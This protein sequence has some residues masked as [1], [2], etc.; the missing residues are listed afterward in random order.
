MI[1]FDR[2]THYL[3]K[4]RVALPGENHRTDTRVPTSNLSPKVIEGGLCFKDYLRGA[5][6]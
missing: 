1:L 4:A 6:I 3:A 5:S 2:V